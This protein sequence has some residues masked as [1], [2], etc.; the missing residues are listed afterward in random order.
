MVEIEDTMIEAS[1]RQRIVQSQEISKLKGNEKLTIRL[2]Q[3]RN[4]KLTFRIS[5]FI[6]F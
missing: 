3:S 5:S 2:E 4:Q 6:E 1:F